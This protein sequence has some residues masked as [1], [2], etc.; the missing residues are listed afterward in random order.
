MRR[1]L[2]LGLKD[3]DYFLEFRLSKPKPQPEALG[4]TLCFSSGT[5]E[6][7][8]VFPV[9]KTGGLPS[10]SFPS[11]VRH[12]SMTVSAAYFAF[13]YFFEKSFVA[14]TTNHEG[15]VNIFFPT[16]VVEVKNPMVFYCTVG[17]P[18]IFFYILD[19]FSLPRSPIARI[20]IFSLFVCCGVALSVILPKTWRAPY[21]VAVCVFCAFSKLVNAFILTAP[22]TSF[23]HLGII[24]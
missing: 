12:Y 21:L 10:S 24:T 6:L 9:P 15:Y 8:R 2:A 1:N 13:P 23:N 18:K 4:I 5:S 19:Y 16:H 22:R 14:I 17:T 7:N 11:F 3:C 20:S